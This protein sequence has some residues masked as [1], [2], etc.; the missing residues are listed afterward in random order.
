MLRELI[1]LLFPLCLLIQLG[2]S[3]SGIDGSSASD[4]D[5][6]GN[7]D[8]DADADLDVDGDLDADGDGDADT[9]P[10]VELPFDYLPN[11]CSDLYNPN[12]VPVFEV[13]IS[14]GEWRGMKEDCERGI[15]AYRP[16]VFRYGE[17]SADAMMR[18]K[19]NWSWRCEKKQFVIS[20]N[21]INSDGRFHGLRKI[22][23]DAPWYDPTLLHERVAFSYLEDRGSPFSCVNNARLYINGAYY[24][25][26]ANVERID[27]EYLERQFDDPDGNLYKEGRELKTNESDPNVDTSRMEAFWAARTLR[28][29]EAIMEIPQAILIWSTL[30]TVPDPD[31]YWAG[32]EI[33][34]Y[35][36]DHPS[37]GLQFIPYDMD[38]SFA[39]EVW[40]ELV[41]ADPITYE[42]WEWLREEPYRIVLEDETWCTTY[43]SAVAAAYSLYDVA[44]LE[45]RIGAWSAQIRSA[46]EED[47]NR[48][49]TLEEHSAA[50]EQM[51]SF[52]SRRKAFVES[53]LAE[54]HCP[55]H[56]PESQ[57][58]DGR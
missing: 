18:L 5:A 48:T 45:E 50:V 37:R 49:F 12:V 15:K 39:E 55:P 51:R 24:G 53:W 46:V 9:E 58:P 16:I 19:G 3:P 54:E 23:L 31:S 28:D 47:P 44:R 22:V 32:V 38:I 17:E 57:A 35:L 42:H 14:E 36:Y 7:G 25:A 21:E 30:A 33:N 20:F 2:C 8:G 26:Y 6:D 27:R 10:R 4:K 56:W 41:E 1:F 40:P 52:P 29:L 11:G 43:Q 13:E 34:F